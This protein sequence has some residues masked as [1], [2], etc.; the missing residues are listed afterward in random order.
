VV[1]APHQAAVLAAA[2]QNRAFNFA[3]LLYDNQGTE[4]TGWL[5][6]SLVAS[7][8]RS[9]PNLQVRR[10]LSERNSAEVKAQAQQ[11]AALAQ[12]DRVKGTPTL[13]VGK[14]GRQGKQVLLKSPTDE[15]ALV[16]AIQ[17]ALA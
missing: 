8:A 15:Q 2:T 1:R 6:N 12:A 4:N 11:V 10:L 9:I 17:A 5:N 14:S 16:R 3:E 13:F 7:V